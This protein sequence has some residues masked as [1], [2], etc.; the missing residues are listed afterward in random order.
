MTNK[1]GSMATLVAIIMM[2]FCFTTA[3]FASTVA[4]VVIGSQT[5]HFQPKVAYSKLVLRISSPDGTVFEKIFRSGADPMIG[6]PDG[7]V[8]GVYNYEL[9]V[10]QAMTEQ[11][12]PEGSDAQ[13]SKLITREAAPQALTENGSFRVQ[14][15]SIILPEGSEAVNT[16]LDVLH[17]DDVIVTG[18]ICVGFDCAD[19]EAFG[20]DTLKLKEN[21]VRLH[22]EDTSTGSFPSG[23]WKL[24]VNDTTSGGASY[25]SIQDATNARTVFKIETGAPSNSMHVDDYGRVGLGTAIPYVELHIVDGD[26]PTVRLDQDGSSGW[27]A[28]RWD[29]CGN[30]TNFFVRDVTNG[31]KLCFRIQPNTPSNALCL[32][33]TGNVGMGTWSPEQALEIERTGEDVQMIIDRTD[34]ATAQMSAK[35]NVVNI[36]SQTNHPVKFMV[37]QL[38]ALNLKTDGSLLLGN[39]ASC[40]IAGVWTNASSIELKEN[41][42]DL[43]TEDAVATLKELNPVRYNYKKEKGEEYLG[44]IAEQVP[45]MVATSDRKG[46]SAMDVVAVLTKVVQKQQETI[47]ELKEII[48]ETNK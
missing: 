35:E 20:Y 36:G 44:F 3:S 48:K 30:E 11:I 28:Q 42:R 47:E 18:S 10:I 17:Y 45:D 4:D 1:K 32:R 21:N 38:M 40:T 29:M 34:G 19:G 9:R 41:V 12:R 33:S 26:S 43:S 24:V 15:G 37:N 7:A 5:L 14:G 2:I 6:L 27:V 22:F 46:M 8:D 13:S 31:S 16:P 25:F 39:G 23:D